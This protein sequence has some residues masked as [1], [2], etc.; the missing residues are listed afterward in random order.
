[1]IRITS[2]PPTDLDGHR[3]PEDRPLVGRRRQ[4]AN[5]HGA[6]VGNE[7]DAR[8]EAALGAEPARSWA[9]AM[10]KVRFLLERFGA[11]READDD[12]IRTLIKRALGDMAWLKKPEERKQ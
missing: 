12:R 3:N 9:D 6:L 11:T 4:A 2:E 10:T 8:L 5:A 7:A 1:M